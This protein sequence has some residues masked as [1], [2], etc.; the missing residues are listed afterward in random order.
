MKQF[1]VLI[2]E[3]NELNIMYLSILLKKWEIQTEVAKNG[4]EA[5]Q[6]TAKN[7]YDLIFMD[8][9]MPLKNGFEAT[10]AIRN[11]ENPN[12]KSPIIALTA[13]S[14]K[15]QMKKAKEI[16]MDEFLS[17]PFVPNQIYDIIERYN[18]SICN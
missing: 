16:G 17:K 11:T 4:N 9:H 8:I 10:L 1:K 13:D 12:Q 3:D 2:V 14:V 15:E 18:K 6:M 5:I 7:K